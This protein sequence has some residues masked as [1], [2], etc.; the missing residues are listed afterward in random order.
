[1]DS[2]LLAYDGRLKQVLGEISELGGSFE[3][4]SQKKIESP[5]DSVDSI[6]KLRVSGFKGYYLAQ[7]GLSLINLIG[8]SLVDDPE[9]QKHFEYVTRIEPL[10]QNALQSMEM[11]KTL[12]AKEIIERA[13]GGTPSSQ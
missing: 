11:Y 6:N 5:D 1:M 3:E 13:I 8:I 12:T 10:L 4:V 9:S 7:E 2:K